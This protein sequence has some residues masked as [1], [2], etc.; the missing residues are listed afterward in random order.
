MKK[1]LLML[2]FFAFMLLLV[3]CGKDDVN[4]NVEN[5]AEVEVNNEII[6]VDPLE[7]LYGKTSL[8]IDD[9]GLISEN[10]LPVSYSYEVYEGGEKVDGWNYKYPQWKDSLLP[11]Y[12]NVKDSTLNSSELENGMIYTD[13][14]LELK[15]GTSA[16]VIYI[17]DAGSLRYLAASL[18]ANWKTTLYVFSY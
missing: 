7:E 14:N 9:L 10:L 1:K 13:V 15:D 18:D 16:S 4:D 8:S 11:V 12:D 5:N 17:N 2:G 3:W 6:E